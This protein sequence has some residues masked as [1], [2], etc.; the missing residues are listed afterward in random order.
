VFCTA[1]TENIG[2]LCNKNRLLKFYIKYVLKS[3]CVICYFLSRDALRR[4][5]SESSLKPRVRD[6]VLFNRAGQQRE[7]ESEV[8]RRP[9]ASYAM[10]P[11]DPIRWPP[12]ERLGFCFHVG[13]SHLTLLLH[14]RLRSN[15]QT[16]L[17]EQGFLVLHSDTQVRRRL[18]EGGRR[19]QGA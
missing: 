2:I 11:L 15:E 7:T 5:L 16:L 9:R 12:H 18:E 4:V 8:T 13:Y 6:V 14:D 3:R 17:S 10:P 1:M 19:S